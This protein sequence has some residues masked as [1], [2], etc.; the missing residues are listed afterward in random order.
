VKKVIKLAIDGMTF[1]ANRAIVPDDFDGDP[2]HFVCPQCRQPNNKRK[3]QADCTQ[4]GFTWDSHLTIFR[5]KCGCTFF[6]EYKVWHSEDER[7][8]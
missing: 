8:A 6:G 4:Y 2:R 1:R 5:C 3:P 7:T